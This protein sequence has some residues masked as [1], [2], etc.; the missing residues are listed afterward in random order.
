M[1][2]GAFASSATAA[3]TSSSTWSRDRRTDDP[4]ATGLAMTGAPN[5][6]MTWSA[7]GLTS[8]SGVGIPASRRIRFVTS[9]SMDRAHPSMPLPA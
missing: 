1:G 6:S 5:R 7:V 9:L 2:E 8:Q 4:P 3:T